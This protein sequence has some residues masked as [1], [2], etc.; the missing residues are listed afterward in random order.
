M[1][2]IL[3][4]WNANLIESLNSRSIDQLTSTINHFFLVEKSKTPNE[5]Y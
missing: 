5:G 3:T 2:S 1:S 4:V